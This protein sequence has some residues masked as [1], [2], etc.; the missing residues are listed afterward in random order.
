[1]RKTGR[2]VEAGRRR[3]S[4]QAVLRTRVWRREGL[5]LGHSGKFMKGCEEKTKQNPRPELKGSRPGSW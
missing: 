3:Y 2:A 1:M 5:R 4:G